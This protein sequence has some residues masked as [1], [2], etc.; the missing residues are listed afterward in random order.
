MRQGITKAELARQLGVSRAYV[1]MLANG[2]RK[3]SQKIVG[4]LREL[5]VNN[6]NYN[7]SSLTLVSSFAAFTR[8]SVRIA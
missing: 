3:S 8:S 2:R 6:P 7:I 4:K 5:A 1:T